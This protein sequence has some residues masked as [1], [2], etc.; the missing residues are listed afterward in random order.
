MLTF[1]AEEHK[2]YRGKLKGRN[3]A[4]RDQMF[5]A[6]GI[7]SIND[8]ETLSTKDADA[9]AQFTARNVEYVDNALEMEDFPGTTFRQVF[10]LKTDIDEGADVYTK[11]EYTSTGEADFVD[12]MGDTI[13]MLSTGIA[14]TSRPL[15][16]VAQGYRITRSE[17]LRATR[18]RRP[19]S[20]EKAQSARQ[21]V[22][23]KLDRIFWNGSTANGIYGILNHP[24]IPIADATTG[25]WA[26]ATADQIKA[27][28]LTMVNNRV[29]AT[30]D[31]KWLFQLGLPLSQYQTL[32]QTEKSTS[33]DKTLAKW[34]ID[35]I[36]Q[37]TG[38]FSTNR[39]SEAA[40]DDDDYGIL[41][42][43]GVKW[44]YGL[45]P[46]DVKSIGPKDTSF[47]GKDYAQFVKA[48]GFFTLKP[49]AFEIIE[50]I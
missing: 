20:M 40:A 34:L 2:T 46:A 8:G 33:Y 47:F 14:P 29:A 22:E 45:L 6:N 23:E 28:I 30:L 15:K 5:G 38:F 41:V 39:L 18:A 50:G 35:N 7:R 9:L 1:D 4:L 44:G 13:P 11:E 49:L 32:T 48:G 21:I 43:Q 25:G 10:T 24:G 12:E 37:L 17:I 16:P 42:P 36:P 26:T 19:V 27:D 3:E 31:T